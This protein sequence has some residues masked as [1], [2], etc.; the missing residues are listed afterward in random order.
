LN[1]SSHAVV[2]VLTANQDPIQGALQDYTYLTLRE[3]THLTNGSMN[4][5]A[6]STGTGSIHTGETINMYKACTAVPDLYARM[7]ATNGSWLQC[8]PWMVWPYLVE[9]D[10]VVHL[11]LLIQVLA[12]CTHPLTVLKAALYVGGVNEVVHVE[13]MT[14]ALSHGLTVL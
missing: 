5:M 12:I 13:H 9:G 11:Q 10:L 1:T 8:S 14:L 6:H 2:D 7:I 4:S 3:D